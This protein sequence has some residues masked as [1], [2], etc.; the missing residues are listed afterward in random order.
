[1][2]CILLQKVLSHHPGSLKNQ[3]L[4]IGKCVLTHELNYLLKLRFFLKQGHG[5]VPKIP[6]LGRYLI[7][8]PRFN[9]I[10]VERVGPEPV[11]GGEMPT[12]SK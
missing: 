12:V 9:R 11:Y 3:P 8:P 10:H 6:P 2:E 5:L 4:S 7:A 1:M